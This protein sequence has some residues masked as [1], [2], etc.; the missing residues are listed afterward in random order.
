MGDGYAENRDPRGGFSRHR[1]RTSEVAG[2][3]VERRVR[4]R[5]LRRRPLTRV[6]APAAV[7]YR[8]VISASSLSPKRP[9]IRPPGEAI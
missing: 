9:M 2:A 1:R 6:G 8:L 4:P 7:L 3:T 5:C